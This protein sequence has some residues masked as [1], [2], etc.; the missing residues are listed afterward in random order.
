VIFSLVGENNTYTF[1]DSS[2]TDGVAQITQKLNADTYAVTASYSGDAAYDPTSAKTTLTVN[3][4]TPEIT[5][6]AK[7][8]N[9]A[10]TRYEITVTKPADSTQG[11]MVYAVYSG[12]P[13]FALSIRNDKFENGS[14]TF[15]FPDVFEDYLSDNVSGEFELSA[16]YDGRN[17]QNYQDN[18]VKLAITLGCAHVW[19]TPTWD[20][21]DVDNPTYSTTCTLCA[22]GQTSG[23]VASTKGT[24]VAATVEADAYT[25][26]TATVTLD[27]QTFNDTFHLTEPG[28]MLAARKA[29]FD[30]Y[31]ADQKQAADAMAKTGDSAACAALI[32]AAKSAIDGVTYDESK[33]LDENKAAVDTAANLDQLAADLTDQRA[34]DEVEKKINDIGTV[35]L[36][37]ESKQKIDDAKEAYDNLTDKQKALVGNKDTLETAEDAYQ[38]LEDKDNFEQ[39]KD[40]LKQAAEDK[41][42]DDDSNESK[43]LIDDAIAAIDAMDYDESKTLDENKQAVD[44]AADLDELTEQL[45][46]HRAVYVV[47]FYA[48]GAEIARVPYTFDTK[49]ITA[50]AVPV[51]PLYTGAWPNYE[52]V[53]GGVRI[54]A[55]YTP[56]AA[57]VIAD[58]AQEQGEGRVLAYRETVTFTTGAAALPQGATLRWYVNGEE[59]GTGMNTTVQNPVEDYTVQVKAFTEDGVLYAESELLTVRVDLTLWAKIVGFFKTLIR[60]LLGPVRM[61]LFE[62]IPALLSVFSSFLLSLFRSFGNMIKQ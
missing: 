9:D 58:N 35:A 24:R 49:A 36:T 29:A 7:S 60:S 25:P 34:A 4:A 31:K 26:Y 47:V 62:T 51:K 13:A 22:N 1:T 19:N 38:L 48:V 15:R 6:T 46:E 32:D 61:I 18:I 33:S 59:T 37:D 17:D 20:W 16:V 41:R 10:G 40:E 56:N 3:P 45:K 27:G 54:D 50:P 21:T 39:Y 23:S 43:K 30:Q 5:L 55:V 53:A 8:M 2:I 28:T 42:K 12:L 57:L 44:A 14:Y 11:V 52:L